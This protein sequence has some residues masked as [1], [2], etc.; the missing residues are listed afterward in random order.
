MK[1]TKHDITE[2]QHL[3]TGLLN[4]TKSFDMTDEEVKLTNPKPAKKK[5]NNLDIPILYGSEFKELMRFCNV[6]EL[7]ILSHYKT[8]KGDPISEAAV[9][10]YLAVKE[11]DLTNGYTFG[12]PYRIRQFVMHYGAMK[13]AQVNV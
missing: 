10:R 9:K 13:L 12:V 5:R 7:E 2:L 4:W 6:S 3:A 8:I 11:N 1:I